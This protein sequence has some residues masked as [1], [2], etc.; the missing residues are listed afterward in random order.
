MTIQDGPEPP[1]QGDEEPK[2][3]TRPAASRPAR[4]KPGPRCA[5]TSPAPRRT[6]PSRPTWPGPQPRS[7]TPQAR[8]AEAAEA[9]AGTVSTLAELVKAE[10]AADAQR[11]AVGRIPEVLRQPG[12]ARDAYARWEAAHQALSAAL[13]Q[14]SYETRSGEK[15]TVN[16]I[17][18]DDIAGSL[19]ELPDR[20]RR[21]AQRQALDQ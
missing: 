19:S 18:A 14:R 13:R 20:R 11:R 7:G 12:A 5:V 15:R 8:A 6:G 17:E 10:D 4:R 21:A 16:E 3:P 1:R 2:R 9:Q